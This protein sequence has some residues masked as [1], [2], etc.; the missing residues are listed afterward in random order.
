MNIASIGIRQENIATEIQVQQ[1]V[2]K[3]CDSTNKVI[4]IGYVVSMAPDG[5]SKGVGS[6]FACRA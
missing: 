4:K 6:Y 2:H 1:F 5:Y 3:L